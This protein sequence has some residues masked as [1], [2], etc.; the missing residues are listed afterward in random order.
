MM[1]TAI[2]I[3]FGISAAMTMLL[4]AAL[5]LGARRTVTASANNSS[6]Y[7]FERP[8]RS[9]SRSETLLAA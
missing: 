2:L 9:D 4:V 3:F 1:M 8:H 7:V 6:E 5:A